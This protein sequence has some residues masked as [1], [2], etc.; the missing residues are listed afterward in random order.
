ML[1]QPKTFLTDFEKAAINSIQRNFSHATVTGCLFHMSQ[2]IYR[3]VVDLGFKQQYHSDNM[4]SLKVRCLPALAFLPPTDVVQGFELLAE[5]DVL[6]S[7]L[8]SYFEDSYA[9][10]CRGRGARRRRLHPLYPRRYVE[11]P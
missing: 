9:G 4:F 11:S 10:P 8:I 1:D 2:N 5:D 7:E 3:K 6:P